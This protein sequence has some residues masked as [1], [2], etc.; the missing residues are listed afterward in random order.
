MENNSKLKREF[1]GDIQLEIRY[2]LPKD[3]LYEI[4]NV[5]EQSWKYAYK[6]IIPENYLNSI[7]SGTWADNINKNGAKNI[8]ILEK[9]IIIGTLSFSKSRWEK[10]HDYGEIIS[11]YF[12]ASIYR[13]RPWQSLT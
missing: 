9:D 4:S 5:Y 13:K 2:I 10:Y 12:F 3:N 8:V 1:E 7:P 6:D 11:I